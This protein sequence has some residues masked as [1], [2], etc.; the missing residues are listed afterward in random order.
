MSFST[1]LH[2][3]SSV[4]GVVPSLTAL[5]AGEI[6][7]NTADGKFFTKTITN[8]VKTFL[9]SNQL[10]FSLDES[11]SSINCQHG[12]NGVSGVLSVVLGGVSN[13]VSGAG[14]TVTN[15]SDNTIDGDYA[16][17]GNGSNNTISVEGDFGAILGGQN[18]TLSHPETF[19]LGSNISSHLSGFTYVNNLSSAGKIYGDGSQLTGIV[20][21][22]TEAT[23]LVRTA[24]SNWDIGYN[25]GTAYSLASSTFLTSETDSQ[26]LSFNESTKALSI[27]NGNVVSLSALVDSAGQDSEVRSLSAN[28][29]ST[30]TAVQTNSASWDIVGDRYFTTSIST[31]SIDKGTK[32]FAVSAGLSYI[33]T[34]DITVVYDHDGDRHMHGTILDYNNATGSLTAD[35]KS[36]TGTGT[37]SDWRINIGGTPAFVNSLIVSNDLSDVANPSTALANLSGVSKS[38]LSSL[39]GSWQSTFTTVQTNSASWAGSSSSSNIRKFDMVYSPNTVSYSGT[40]ASGSLTSQGVWTIARI[41]Y[42]TTGTVSAQGTALNAI[43]DNRLSLSYV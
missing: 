2:K 22:D 34:Q 24:S 12:E 17:I 40:A 11:L 29:Q 26:T 15:G 5:S 35:I 9:N 31:N 43:W 25:F 16:F 41:V 27:S 4:A 39:S 36:R 3:R 21:G 33:P 42:T 10:P 13:S 8:E 7:I 1:I 20:A 18:N 32:V 6:A 23:T 14:S 37:Y 19:I 38:E 28:W 30:F